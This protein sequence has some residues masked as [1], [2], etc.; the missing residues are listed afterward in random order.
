[1][2]PP[3][4]AATVRQVRLIYR[5][6]FS[7]VEIEEVMTTSPPST[8]HHTHPTQPMNHNHSDEGGGGAMRRILTCLAELQ[9]A[10]GVVEQVRS[11]FQSLWMQLSAS[12]NSTRSTHHH[13]NN[14]TPKAGRAR[15][16]SHRTRSSRPRSSSTTRCAG[17]RRCWT[18]PARR[19]C[20]RL[21]GPWSRCESPRD[22]TRQRRLRCHVEDL[23]C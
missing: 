11:I 21:R 12:L 13:Y 15:R 20:C 2:A 23:V 17:S 22:E 5:L 8:H 1:M 14:S 3:S 18:G 10:L 16:A 19:S 4:S 7:E 9:G 6:I